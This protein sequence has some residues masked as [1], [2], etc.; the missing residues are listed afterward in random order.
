MSKNKRELLRFFIALP[1]RLEVEIHRAA[2]GGFWAKVNNLRGCVTQ[3]DDFLELIEM[4]NDAVFTYF[5]VPVK[6]RKLLGYYVPK[7]SDG[8]R[9]KIAHIRI[10]KLVSEIIRNRRTLEF[11]RT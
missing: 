2:E 10:E 4:I 1:P 3:A 8:L 5:E 11:S 6:Y 9:K 7:F